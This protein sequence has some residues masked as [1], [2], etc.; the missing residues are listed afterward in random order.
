MPLVPSRLPSPSIALA[1]QIPSAIHPT[2]NN[3]PLPPGQTPRQQSPHSRR[4]PRRQTLH[5]SLRR[6]L[7]R[8]RRPN[9]RAQ[10][11]AR[12]RHTRPVRRPR[13]MRRRA[14]HRHGHGRRPLD[15]RR[16]TR[17]SG[18]G[19]DGRTRALGRR[20]IV[21]ESGR[22]GRAEPRDT[23]QAVHRRRL[24]P[25]GPDAGGT[26]GVGPGDAGVED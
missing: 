3:P 14:P 6:A 24:A 12:R 4:D 16:N 15:P 11:P 8:S 20:Q 23:G 22:R 7:H 18:P 19:A 1:T 2:T 25:D 9:A 5:E 13:Q 21:G 17:R 10:E 26:A